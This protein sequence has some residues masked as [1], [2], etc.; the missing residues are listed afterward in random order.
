MAW[1]A[2]A[3]VRAQPGP[4][5]D[6]VADLCRRRRRV[7]DG[8]DHAR[9]RHLL[10]EPQR[11]R[12]FRGERDQRECVRRPRPASGGTRRGPDRERAPADAPAAAHPPPRCTVLPDETRA[13]PRRPRGRTHTLAAVFA[14]PCA[15]ASNELVTSVGSSPPMPWR[16]HSSTTVRTCTTVSV[17]ELKLIP[18]SR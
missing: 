10:D 3:E 2:V 16:R 15:M 8:N 12:P 1:R 17:G 5:G 6:R 11:P 18:G 9:A 7:A 4:G 14:K 13:P